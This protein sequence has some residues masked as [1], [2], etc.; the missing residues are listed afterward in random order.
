M[1]LLKGNW[2]VRLSLFFGLGF[3]LF[4]FFL[5]SQFGSPIFSFLQRPFAAVG[6]WTGTQWQ[7]LF[8]EARHP[9][10]YAILQ[11][12]I[13]FLARDAVS[14][15]QL[16]TENKNLKEQLAFVERSSFGHVTA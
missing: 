12:R 6:L 13:S 16:R 7:F 2:K 14:Y 11:E 15:E 9:K 5:I 3:F 10:A 8:G 4:F 1:A